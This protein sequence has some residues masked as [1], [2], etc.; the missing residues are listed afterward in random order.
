MTPE[1]MTAEERAKLMQADF[2]RKTERN[3]RVARRYEEL[4]SQ[5]KH[6]DTESMFRVVHEEV[7][8]AENAAYERAAE[9]AKGRIDPEWPGDDLS[10]QAEEIGLAILALRHP[11]TKET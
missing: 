11:D 1:T 3:A 6:G 7:R 9:V 8:A 2:D 10:S 4:V 5:G